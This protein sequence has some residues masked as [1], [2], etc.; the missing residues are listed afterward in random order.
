MQELG[1]T[2]EVLVAFEE[3]VSDGSRCSAVYRA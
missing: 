1:V 2:L 3:Q